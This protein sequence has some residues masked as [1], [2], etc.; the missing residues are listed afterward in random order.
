MSGVWPSRFY[1]GSCRL[2]TRIERMGPGPTGCRHTSVR[3]REQQIDAAVLR[4]LEQQ[5][6][7]VRPLQP[8]GAQPQPLRELVF[9]DEVRG[10]DVAES[11]LQLGVEVRVQ[12]LAGRDLGRGAGV[13]AGLNAELGQV[14]RLAQ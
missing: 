1:R 9:E 13:A 2:D 11:L 12:L 6:L 14:Q 10:A 4:L 3:E 8:V 5:R 7:R